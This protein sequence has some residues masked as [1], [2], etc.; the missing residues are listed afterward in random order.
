MDRISRV[1]RNQRRQVVANVLIGT[2]LVAGVAMLGA[3]AF[4][5]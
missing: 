5:L 2:L 1:L 3:A 4:W